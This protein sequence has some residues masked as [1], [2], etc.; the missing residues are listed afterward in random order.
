MAKIAVLCGGKASDGPYGIDLMSRELGH[1]LLEVPSAHTPAHIKLRDVL[2]HRLGFPLDK[3]V[4][5]LPRIASADVLFCFLESFAVFPSLLKQKKIPPFANTPLAMISCWLAEEIRHLPQSERAQLVKTYAGVDLN[6]V[7]SGNQIDILVDSGF[8]EDRVESVNFGFAPELFSYE[9][10]AQRPLQLSALG[11]D[12]G[13]DYRTLIEAVRPLSI[14]LNLYTRPEIIEGIDLPENVRFHGTVPFEAYIEVLHSSDMVA[15]PT[16]ELAYPTGQTVALE[17]A[18]T[19]AA[20]LLTDSRAMR[21]Y[22]SDDT[23]CFIGQ[24]D[25]EGW[26]RAITDLAQSPEHRRAIGARAAHHVHANLKYIDMWTAIE[27]AFARR[28]WI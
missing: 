27:K 14:E 20:L 19:G 15:V 12:R 23:A 10:G 26:R 6:F 24:G 4:R 2:E 21:Y 8:A 9:A 22:F 11:F 16:V 28:G 1:S 13:R 18:A 7:L 25:V 3:A 5:S 17:A